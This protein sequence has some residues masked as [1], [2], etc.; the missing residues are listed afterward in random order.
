M[1][2][3]LYGIRIGY[4]LA[5]NRR[6]WDALTDYQRAVWTVFDEAERSGDVDAVLGRN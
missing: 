5:T 6:T 4:A 2:T 3:Y 1:K